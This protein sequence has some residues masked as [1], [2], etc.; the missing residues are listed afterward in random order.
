[1]ALGEQEALAAFYDATS[2]LAYG[3]ILRI[4][5]DPATAEEVAL[6]TFKQVWRTSG[7]YSV[8][9]GSP[10]AWLLTIARTRALDRL[11]AGWQEQQR[12]QPLDV[13]S[14]VATTSANPEEESALGEQQRLVRHA[15]AALSP[16]QREAIEL[17]YYSGLSHSEIALKLGQP[18]GTVKT[19]IRLAMVKLRDLLK[20]MLEER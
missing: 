20:P 6:D 2:R 16:E 12:K 18:L 7:R 4:V 19:R 17:A 11:R 8:E 15:L 10:L 1:M 5:G 3:L 13:V 9:R 14:Q